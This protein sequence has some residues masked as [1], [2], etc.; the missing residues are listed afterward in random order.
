MTKNASANLF[1]CKN[2]QRYETHAFGKKIKTPHNFIKFT[3]FRKDANTCI[4]TTINAKLFIKMKKTQHTPAER[5]AVWPGVA[6]QH[7]NSSPPRGNAATGGCFQHTTVQCHCWPQQGNLLHS[8]PSASMFNS[9][10]RCS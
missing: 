9:L 1:T 6:S 2:I 10:L 5:G 3:H 7:L 8:Q 4:A